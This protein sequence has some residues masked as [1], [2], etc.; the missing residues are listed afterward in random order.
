MERGD[1]GRGEIEEVRDLF[2][3]VVTVE[4]GDAVG[5]AVKEEMG[6]VHE[7]ELTHNHWEG[8]E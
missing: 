1:R 4:V 7:G 2:P 5:V 8:V 6:L 3:H